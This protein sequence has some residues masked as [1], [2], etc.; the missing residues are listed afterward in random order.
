MDDRPSLLLFGG[1]NQRFDLAAMANGANLRLIGA[2][3]LEE[4]AQ[5]LELTVAADTLMLDLRGTGP[6]CPYAEAS[7]RAALAWPGLSDASLLVLVD[8]AGLDAAVASLGSAKAML[9]CEP[10]LSDIAMALCIIAGSSRNLARLNDVGREPESIRL[11]RLSDEVRRLA[12]TI[13]RLTQGNDQSDGQRNELGD[14]S[15]LNDMQSAFAPAPAAFGAPVRRPAAR[16]GG[17]STISREEVRALLQARRLRDRYL[18]P[19]LF[20]DP[21]WDMMLDLMAARLAGKRVSVSS[22]CIAAAV[23]PT[24]ALRWIGQLTERGIFLR[25]NDPDDARRVFI[26]LSDEAAENI[27]AWFAAS[28]RAG[29]R[30]GG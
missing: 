30:F 11:D 21:A 10:R 18:P 6:N 27:A 15:R 1:E 7:I 26:S 20:A 16:Q 4:A 8:L 3:A 29:L 13:D 28:R 12:Q 22:L 17:S 23:P 24:T 5:R 25:A 2:T 19:D 14:S 9:L